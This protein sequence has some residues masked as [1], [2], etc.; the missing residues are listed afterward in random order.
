MVAASSKGD[1]SLVVLGVTSHSA[2]DSAAI[3]NRWA[4]VL[5]RHANE[6]YGESEGDVV[7]FEEQMAQAE[8]AANQAEAALVEFQAR[9]LSTI[10]QA[11]LTSF[12]TTQ[13]D[14]LAD[15]RQI[16]YIIQDILGLRDH[17]ARQPQDQ[18]ISLADS[19][20]ALSLQVMAFNAKA[21]APIEFQVAAGE[22]ISDKSLA[23]Q[24][25]LLDDLVAT[26][27][28]KSAVVDERLEELEPQ[29]LASQEERQRLETEYDRLT[30][31]RDLS[32]ETYKTLARKLEEVRISAQGEI[33]ALQVGSYATVPQIPVGPRKTLMALVAGVLGLVVGAF[34]AIAIELWHR[35]PPQDTEF[36]DHQIQ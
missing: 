25:A 36:D 1:P 9:N 10:V 4:D 19:L 13:S 7:F 27:Q 29:I 3:A 20:T 33:G 12:R 34:L 24:T 23:E 35:N 15:Q 26:L 11:Q 2:Q 21:P 14:Y 18:S 32:L 6:I 30:R 16:T 8:Q 22:T 5:V 17:I 31:D 28:A